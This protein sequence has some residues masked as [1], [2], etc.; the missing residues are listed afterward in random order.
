MGFLALFSGAEEDFSDCNFRCLI[1]QE[2]LRE[3]FKRMFKPR[4]RKRKRSWSPRI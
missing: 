1:I 4:R 2:N 3:S